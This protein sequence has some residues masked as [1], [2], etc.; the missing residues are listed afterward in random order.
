LLDFVPTMQ[1]QDPQVAWSYLDSLVRIDALTGLPAPSL[2]RSWRWSDDGLALTFTL[3]DDVAWHDGTPFTAADA[4]FAHI[5]YRDDYR[6]VIAGQSALVSDIVAVD[7]TTVRV[8]FSEP[9]G[10]WLFNVA[11]L[12]VVQRAQYTAQWEANPLGERTLEGIT[13]E[14]TLPVGTGPWVIESIGRDRISF[15]RN[16]DYF[17][18]PP[19]TDRLELISVDDQAERITMWRAGELHVVGNL[20]PSRVEGLLQDEGRL[21]VADAPRTLFAAFNFDNVGRWEP[22]LLGTPQVREAVSL[23]LD[24]ERYAEEIWGGFLRH[25][26]AGIVAQTWVDGAEQRNPEQDLDRARELMEEAGWEDTTGDDIVESPAGDAFVLTALVLE[27]AAPEVVET[28]E[29]MDADLRK[30]GGGIGINVVP[31]DR[32]VTWYSEE[33]TWDLVVYDLRLYPAFNE[34]DL[35]G[36]AWDIRTNPSGWNPGGYS[37]PAADAALEAYFESVDVEEMSAALADLQEAITDDPFAVWL[38][39]PQDLTLLAPAVRGFV[40]NP[41]W[42]TLDTRLMWLDGDD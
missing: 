24:R 40:P 28:L 25:E 10:A 16:P 33:R 26:R 38:G 23:A 14:E 20:L 9:D 19:H 29:A 17:D 22:N 18:T 32:F 5:V 41:V 39:F 27:P 7:E 36:S 21:I 11:S 13:F 42:S 15:A 35:I 2:A 4:R 30:I 12:P 1:R 3:R 8:E 34:F 37:N 6:S 31:R